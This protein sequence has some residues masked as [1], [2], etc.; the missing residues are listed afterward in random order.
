MSSTNIKISF[1]YQSFRKHG[2]TTIA[3][4]EI[5]VYVEIIMDMLN[6]RT[7]KGDRLMEVASFMNRF[8]VRINYLYVPI[9]LDVGREFDKTAV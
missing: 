7:V 1:Y 9:N 8:K 4:F 6:P 2:N 3:E 5:P